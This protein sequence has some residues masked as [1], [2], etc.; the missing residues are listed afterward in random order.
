M[1]EFNRPSTRGKRKNL[2]KTQTDAEAALWDRLRDRR[3]MDYKFNRQYGIGEYVADFYCPRNRLVI[4]ID[5]SQHYTEDGRKYDESR[6]KYM[7]SLSIKTVRFSNLDVL[8]NI[9]GVLSE[10]SKEL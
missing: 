6:E 5:G 9:E 4:E 7:S 8:Q 2:R 3:F 10:I 1:Q